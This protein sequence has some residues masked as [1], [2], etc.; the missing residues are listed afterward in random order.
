MNPHLLDEIEARQ[1]DQLDV[2]LHYATEWDEMWSYVGS[3]ANPRWTWYL[4]E[5]NSG[6]IV[7]WENGRRQDEVLLRLLGHVAHL[8]LRRCYTDD[9]GAYKRLL[10]SPYQHI[11]G[12]AD[13][14]KI[15]RRNLNFRTHLKRLNR[16]TICFSKDERI[17]D[18][19]IGMYIER[20]YFRH[21]SYAEA[22]SA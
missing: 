20:H 10:H 4:L 21:G 1:L 8:P 6:R 18:N 5:R 13:T 9:W 17:H 12:K 15:E 14:W 16:R 19:V 2:E 11:I 22:V 7:A 3:K